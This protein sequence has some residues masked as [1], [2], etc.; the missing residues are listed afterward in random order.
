[1]ATRS[2]KLRD[3]IP[4]LIGSTLFIALLIVASFFAARHFDFLRYSAVFSAIVAGWT[5]GVKR[6]PS[7]LGKHFC[8]AWNRFLPTRAAW[9]TLGAA[10]L[11]VVSVGA[12]TASA[13]VDTAKAPD[14]FVMLYRMEQPSAPRARPRVVDSARL[15]EINLHRNFLMRAVFS[16]E[17]TWIMTSRYTRTALLPKTFAAA[18]PLVYDADFKPVIGVALLPMQDFLALMGRNRPMRVVVTDAGGTVVAEDSLTDSRHMP[19]LMLSYDNPPPADSLTRARWTTLLT[20]EANGEATPEEISELVTDWADWQWLAAS[21]ELK[22][23]EK[24][25][26]K[27]VKSSSEMAGS[28]VVTLP[29]R[30]SDVIVRRP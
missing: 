26:V 2:A 10:I 13:H 28:T 17:P 21:R 14:S 7:F 16:N 1:M 11:L 22:A 6:V 4:A 9:W 29:E 8:E 12:V 19:A 5:F 24:L 3:L 23:G 15:D 18:Y 27:L 30:F 20:K 25:Q